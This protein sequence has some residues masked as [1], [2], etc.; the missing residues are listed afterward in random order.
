[1]HNSENKIIRVKVLLYLFVFLAFIPNAHAG[2]EEITSLFIPVASGNAEN[3]NTSVNKEMPDSQQD[4]IV[5]VVPLKTEDEEYYKVRL[6]FLEHSIIAKRA[7]LLPGPQG[8]FTWI[9]KPENLEGVVVVSTCNNTLFGRIEL[10]DEVYKIEPVRGTNTHRIFKLDPG[11]ASPV[12]AGGLIPPSDKFPDKTSV[13][14]PV[15]KGI[16]D[17]KTFDI[18]VLYTGGF[19]EAYPG[20]ELNA[21]INYLVGVANACY[22]N[23]NVNLTARIVKLHEVDYKDGGAIRD[24]L[25]DLTYGEG[26]F[27]DVVDFRNQLG[28]D[29]VTLLRVFKDSND[30]CGQA[31]QMSLLSNSFERWAFSV[32]QVGKVTYGNGYSYCTDQT[33]AHE[34]GHNM[35]CAH[36]DDYGGVFEYSQGYVFS[37][38]MSVMASSGGTR[39]SHF[40]NPNVSYAGLVTGAD[41][42]NNALSINKVKLTISQFRDSKCL[43]SITVSP[44]KLTLD[45]EEGGEVTAT[46]MSEYDYPA[47]GEL[48]KVKVNAAGKKLISVL[49]ESDITNSDGRVSFTITA[50]KKAGRARITFKAGCLK[51]SII[52]KIR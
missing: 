20:D 17:G 31:W 7:R 27:S 8:S 6:N 51:E 32:V 5:N 48:V 44:G 43:G 2:R 22:S 40:S 24:A 16:D 3:D 30:V 41:D 34:M 10:N 14:P 38:Y 29:L 18:L 49:P 1:M 39:V 45:R 4:V 50:M 47:E 23:S 25:N 52:V 21:Q 37:P 9:G 15:P 35:G 13:V 28:A 42:A 19:A 11:E 36:A 46:V 33:L 26:V 12:D